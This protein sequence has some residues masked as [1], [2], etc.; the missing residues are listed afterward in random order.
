MVPRSIVMLLPPKKDACASN[1]GAAA[2]MLFG[3]W[4]ALP[5][6][7]AV[8]RTWP[9]RKH[10]RGRGRELQCLKCYAEVFPCD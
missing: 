6:E 3:K 2:S 5:Y 10:V 8:R 9:G 4:I 1:S 7:I